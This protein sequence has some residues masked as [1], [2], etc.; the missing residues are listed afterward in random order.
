MSGLR[1]GTGQL[2]SLSKI[3]LPTRHHLIPTK[4]YQRRGIVIVEAH[5]L[6][7]ILYIG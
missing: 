1:E 3:V 5:C 7:A 4:G 2:A 6:E